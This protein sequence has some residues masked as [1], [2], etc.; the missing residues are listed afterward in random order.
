MLPAM[1]IGI[2][3]TGDVHHATTAS[4]L[5]ATATYF[6]LLSVLAAAAG[7][8]FATSRQWLWK[9]GAVV[10]VV[11]AAAWAGREVAQAAFF[12]ECMRNM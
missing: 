8:A 1:A 10:F 3:M 7:V 5:A 4:D 11:L 9:K 12:S 2:L 6:A